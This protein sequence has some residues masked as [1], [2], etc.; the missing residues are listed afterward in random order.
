VTEGGIAV[1]RRYADQYRWRRWSTVYPLLG[2]LSNTTVLDLGCG[3]GDQ[4][5]DLCRLGAAVVG[6]DANPVVIEHA[7]SRGIPRARFLC[8]NVTDL[9][10]HDLAAGGVWASFSPACFPRFEVFLQ[11]V[12]R[13]LAPGGWLALTEVDD[14]FGHE[15]LAA[16]WRDLVERYYAASLEEGVYRFRS[17]D[18]VAGVLAD[19]G[20][21]VEIDRIL[22]DDEFS[23]AGPAARD[24]LEAWRTRLEFMMPRFLDRFGDAARGFDAA[25]LEC[26]GSREHRSHSRVW[27][28]LARSPANRASG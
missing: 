25:F 7:A 11:A 6:I 4:A 21:R 18:H 10:R 23:L 13:V 19:R 22:E 26:L 14:L 15:P 16:R 3:I 2:D 24:V 5:R 12:D 27:F 8:E 9:G 20:W 17:R 1:V 28:V